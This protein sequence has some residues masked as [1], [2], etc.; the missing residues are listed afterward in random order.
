[1][2]YFAAELYFMLHDLKFL[3]CSVGVRKHKSPASRVNSDASDLLFTPLIQPLAA[4]SF[5]F[6]TGLSHEVIVLL[7][8]AKRDG[9][10]DD[11]GNIGGKVKRTFC[12]WKQI[13]LLSRCSQFS[14]ETLVWLSGRAPKS[15]EA[16][17]RG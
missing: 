5:V 10:R 16:G 17:R 12:I 2:I 3:F 1:M 6:S 11:V 9:A 7:L 15:T 4:Y 14:C 8:F 13:L